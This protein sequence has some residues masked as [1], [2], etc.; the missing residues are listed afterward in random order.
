[1]LRIYPPAK[2]GRTPK[3]SRTLAFNLTGYISLGSGS[4]IWT[5]GASLNLHGDGSKNIQ[6][7]KGKGFTGILSKTATI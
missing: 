6:N 5:H 7:M 3:R 1:M 4:G 2:L